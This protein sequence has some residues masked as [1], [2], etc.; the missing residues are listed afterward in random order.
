M[1]KQLFETV[2]I[3]SLLNL[4]SGLAKYK[5]ADEKLMRGVISVKLRNAIRDGRDL[6]EVLEEVEE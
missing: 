4:E 2:A 3:Q 1:S 6:D 5:S